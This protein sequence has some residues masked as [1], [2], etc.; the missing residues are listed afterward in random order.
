MQLIL[1]EEICPFLSLSLLS[2]SALF[3]LSKRKPH[4]V[5]M[6]DVVTSN[7][8]SFQFMYITLAGV[9]VLEAG[10]YIPLESF[11]I[12]VLKMSYFR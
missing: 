12:F 4:S 6:L 5:K 11:T 9:T 10:W 1:L 3:C 7:F 2:E 8:S